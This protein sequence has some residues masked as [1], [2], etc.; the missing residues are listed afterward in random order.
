MEYESLVITDEVKMKWIGSNR[1]PD[2]KCQFG[3]VTAELWLTSPDWHS[4]EHI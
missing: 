2:K 4:L 3:P 1:P